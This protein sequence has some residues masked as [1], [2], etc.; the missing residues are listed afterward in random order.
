[1]AQ[2][3]LPPCRFPAGAP[4]SAR[5]RHLPRPRR[6]RPPRGSL[7]DPGKVQCAPLHRR[8]SRLRVRRAPR[9]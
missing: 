8:V 9:R 5:P 1:M 3:G 7:P 4:R 2:V 6:P